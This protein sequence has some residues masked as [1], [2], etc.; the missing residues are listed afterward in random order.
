MKHSNYEFDTPP[1]EIGD[2]IICEISGKSIIG[3]ILAISCE[4]VKV[5]IVGKEEHHRLTLHK[6]YCKRIDSNDVVM[7]LLAN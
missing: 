2:Y 3:E 6:K 5:H 7:Y 1:M 4:L